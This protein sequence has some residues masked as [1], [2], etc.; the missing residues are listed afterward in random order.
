MNLPS[1]ER[2]KNDVKPGGIIIYDALMGA[3]ELP[4][5]IR[6][7]GVPAQNLAEQAGNP[8]G[9]NTIMLGVMLALEITGLP[10]EAFVKALE[11]NFARKPKLIGP[12]VALLEV[13]R[14]WVAEQ[15][16]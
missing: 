16:G 12:N 2:F 6:G 1:F 15:A 8:R 14:S 13:A 3:V 4:T 5:G 11:E 9:A 10:A 7:V